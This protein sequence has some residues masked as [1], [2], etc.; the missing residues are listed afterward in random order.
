MS[1]RKIDTDKIA[2]GLRAGKRGTVYPT[3]GYPGAAQLTAEVQARFRVPPGGG[4]ATDPAWSDKRLVPIAPRTLKR[5]ERIAKRLHEETGVRVEPMQL[6]AI[7]LETTIE[8]IGA[9][10][11]ER[12]VTSHRRSDRS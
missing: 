8:N 6:A 4:R 5:L 10:D 12:L 9:E 7:L 1:K 2:R 11:A 3:G